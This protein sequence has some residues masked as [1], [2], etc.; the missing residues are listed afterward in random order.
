MLVSI[1]RSSSAT[2]DGSPK[3]STVIVVVV[4][5]NA[6]LPGSISVRPPGREKD[7]HRVSGTKDSFSEKNVTALNFSKVENTSQ[8]IN[9]D[10]VFS[11]FES[12]DFGN[13]FSQILFAT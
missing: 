5:G 4:Y 11:L 2:T 12:N 9:F 8:S 3:P 13:L 1:D 10:N 6:S 7:R